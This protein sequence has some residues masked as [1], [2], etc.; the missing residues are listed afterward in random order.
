MNKL[1]LLL[2]LF[3][4]GCGSNPI[5]IKTELI[6]VSPPQE[7][8]LDTSTPT[9][10]GTTNESLIYWIA[11]LKG[12]IESCNL[13]KHKILEWIKNPTSSSD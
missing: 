9:L 13:D 12:Q 8:L 4:I 11:E 3:L 7:F 6:K 10:D 1:V 5:Q 2:P